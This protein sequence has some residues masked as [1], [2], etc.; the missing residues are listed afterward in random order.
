MWDGSK[1]KNGGGGLEKEREGKA[2]Q[3]G[4][5]GLH[6]AVERR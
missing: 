1:P 3:D 6:E 4:R 5:K 2:R